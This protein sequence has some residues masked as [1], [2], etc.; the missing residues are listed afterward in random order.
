MVGAPAAR[1][2]FEISFPIHHQST[3][4]IDVNSALAEEPSSTLLFIWG[5]IVMTRRKT[6]EAVTR[7]FKELMMSILPFGGKLAFV[8]KI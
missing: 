3:W 7:N 4:S 2:A 6:L 8:S 1:S 5:E